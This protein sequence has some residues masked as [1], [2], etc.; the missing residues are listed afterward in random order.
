V[1]FKEQTVWCWKWG[2][3]ALLLFLLLIGIMYFLAGIVDVKRLLFVGY[4]I[5]GALFV[6]VGLLV[7]G[8]LG[9][10][11]QKAFY[12]YALEGNDRYRRQLAINPM[13]L[14]LWLDSEGRNRD[15]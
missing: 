6:A 14:W 4:L 2:A 12:H 3:A 8:G 15:A 13:A 5:S 9:R 1:T 7:F 10:P 11:I